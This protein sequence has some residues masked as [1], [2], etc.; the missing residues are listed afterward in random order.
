M[1]RFRALILSVLAGC[2]AGIAAAQPV[3]D[4]PVG[5]PI[6]SVLAEGL[7]ERG[8][9]GI[10]ADLADVPLVFRVLGPDDLWLPFANVV[11]DLGDHGRIL[12]GTA[13]E[14]GEISITFSEEMLA[15]DPVVSGEKDGELLPVHFRFTAPVSRRE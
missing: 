9:I 1:N 12:I 14:N 6:A 15:L 3:D 8:V 5:T 11:V 7:I 13:D 10:A 2:F 4:S